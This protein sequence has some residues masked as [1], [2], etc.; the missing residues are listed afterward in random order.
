[1]KF[2]IVFFLI[3]AE[4][5]WVVIFLSTL[6]VQIVE[7]SVKNNPNLEDDEFAEFEEFDDDVDQQKLRASSSSKAGEN[8]QETPPTTNKPQSSPPVKEEKIKEQPKPQ[9]VSQQ[10]QPVEDVSDEMMDDL[11]GIVE[12]SLVFF[13]Q[14]A[15]VFKLHI[16]GL[17]Q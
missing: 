5:F 7:T 8:Q 9:K 16:D 2:L 13:N 4:Y 10:K 14:K 15:K 3:L 12:V 6:L 1:M 11:E 17:K